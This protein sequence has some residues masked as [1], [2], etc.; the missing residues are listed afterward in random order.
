[1]K[2]VSVRELQYNLATVLQQVSRG[3]EIAVTRHGR[4]IAH[5]VPAR[6]QTGPVDWP[7]SA[8]RMKRLGPDAARG[9]PPSRILR[10]MRGER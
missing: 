3:E 4:L 8:A 10:E 1:M 9:T 7:D 6:A 5:I 2:T